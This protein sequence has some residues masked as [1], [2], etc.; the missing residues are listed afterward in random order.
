[1]QGREKMNA[2]SLRAGILHSASLGLSTLDSQ[3]STQLWLMKF[4]APVWKA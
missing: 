4:I 2:L 3:L 1:M